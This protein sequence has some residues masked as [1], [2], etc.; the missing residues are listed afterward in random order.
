M[1][2][3][4]KT[5][6][7]A[8]IAASAMVVPMTMSAQPASA[9]TVTEVASVDMHTAVDHHKPRWHRG[10]KKAKRVVQNIFIIDSC[11]GAACAN[12]KRAKGGKVRGS[13]ASINFGPGRR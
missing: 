12:G 5:L 11:V 7:A 6:A 1:I 4:K 13:R 10:P 8:T 3:I 2:A 9:A